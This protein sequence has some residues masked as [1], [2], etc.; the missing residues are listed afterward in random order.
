MYR[1]LT[2]AVLATAVLL[3]A[4][5]A[6][7]E[8]ADVDA[9]ALARLQ[10]MATYLRGLSAFRVQAVTTK[11]DVLDDG[12]KIQSSGTV[13][14]IAKMPNRLRAEV[15]SDRSARLFFYDGKTFTL[16]APLVDYYASVPAPATTGQLARMLDSTYDFSLPLEDLFL[17]GTAGWNSKAIEAVTDVGPSAVDGT[18]CEQYAVRQHDVDWQIWV[19]RGEYPL[20]RK[21]VITTKTDEARPQYSAVYTW[22]LAPSFNDAAFAFVPPPGTRRVALSKPAL[23]SKP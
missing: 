7:A 10:K 8:S 21:I 11:E 1:M 5:V 12:E 15:R 3:S 14:L 13:D 19:Q 4:D 6:G 18:T 9:D 16:F 20:P 22:N 23:D 17:W 2:V